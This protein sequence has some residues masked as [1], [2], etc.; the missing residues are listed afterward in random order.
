VDRLLSICVP[1]ARTS[2]GASAAI[3]NLQAAL[4]DLIRLQ[5]KP[6]DQIPEWL[7]R[8]AHTLEQPE[9]PAGG[10]AQVAKD[11]GVSYQTFRKRFRT[12]FGLSPHKYRIRHLMQRA[13][14]LLTE[15]RLSVKETAARVGFSDPYH[16]SRTFREVTGRSPSAVA[17][18]LGR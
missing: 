17:A 13:T 10:F 3:V 8:G 5:S 6:D 15:E 7:E 12:R 1:Q 18:R 2:A 9:L 4:I 11:L 14:V 16:F